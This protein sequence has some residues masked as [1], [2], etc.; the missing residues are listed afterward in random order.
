MTKLATRNL[1]FLSDVSSDRPETFFGACHQHS[2][3]RSKISTLC[4]KTLGRTEF[5]NVQ[6]LTILSHFFTNLVKKYFFLDQFWRLLCEQMCLS[7]VYITSNIFPE[8]KFF[9]RK[10]T[11]NVIFWTYVWAPR[12]RGAGSIFSTFLHKNY[13]IASSFQNSFHFNKT[14]NSGLRISIYVFYKNAKFP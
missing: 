2:Q 7:G 12:S 9:D 11:K 1:P 3:H 6:K 13:S 5:L 14:P 8:Q 4:L 10:M